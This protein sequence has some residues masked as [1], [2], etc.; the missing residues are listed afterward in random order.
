MGRGPTLAERKN[1]IGVDLF[2]GYVI[3]GLPLRKPRDRNQS[4]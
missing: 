1:G 2:R 3:L 4:F